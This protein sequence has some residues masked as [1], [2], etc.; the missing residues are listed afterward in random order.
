[1][2]ALQLTPHID[3]FSHPRFPSL[4]RTEVYKAIEADDVDRL[5][6]ICVPTAKVTG[7]KAQ[8]MYLVSAVRSVRM[9]QLVFDFETNPH[10][11]APLAHLFFRH[12]DAKV[13]HAYLAAGGDRYLIPN[14]EPF[15][16][17][18]WGLLIRPEER[19]SLFEVHKFQTWQ[20]AQHMIWKV[21]R[22][23]LNWV[24]SVLT[25]QFFLIE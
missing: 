3:C 15:Y 5:A 9:L 24:P 18:E 8:I 6:A 11:L 17:P 12:P 2:A 1:M 25:A 4:S 19:Q 21:L 16:K 20:R 13:L 10:P 14:S 22:V 7:K 23:C